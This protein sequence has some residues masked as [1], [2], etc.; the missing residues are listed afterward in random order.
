MHL[1]LTLF[2]NLSKKELF[3]ISQGK[4]ADIAE[5]LTDLL[6]AK[7]GESILG[8]AGKIDCPRPILRKNGGGSLAGYR[9]GVLGGI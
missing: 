3:P 1:L 4:I 9:Q 5:F 2:S 7:A 8:R 6:K